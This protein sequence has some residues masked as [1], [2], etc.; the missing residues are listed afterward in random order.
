MTWLGV[1]SRC[2]LVKNPKYG[3]EVFVSNILGCQQ[4][5]RLVFL[6]NDLFRYLSIGSMLERL[7][8]QIVQNA[9]VVV[10]NGLLEL[11]L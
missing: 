4:N 10:S 9:I 5:A 3:L 11:E 2:G 1:S 6:T 8:E 7:V